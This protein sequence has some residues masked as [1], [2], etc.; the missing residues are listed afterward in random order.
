[1]PSRALPRIEAGQHTCIS[2]NLKHDKPWQIHFVISSWCK[3]D[4]FYCCPGA[5]DQPLIVIVSTVMSSGEERK[6]L[7]LSRYFG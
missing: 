5:I 3:D 6:Y 4:L 2:I 1:M 7:Y